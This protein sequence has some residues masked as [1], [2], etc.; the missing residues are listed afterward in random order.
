MDLVLDRDQPLHFIGVGGIG[1]SALAGILVERGFSV[2]GSDPKSNP[3]LRRLADRGVKVFSEQTEATILRLL[4]AGA[5][6]PWVVLSSAVRQTN[7]EV[8][9]A[10]RQG[11]R[12]CHRSDVLAALINGQPSIAVAGSHG[13]TTTSTLIATLLE[14]T[15]QDPTAVIGGIVPAFDSNGR[16]G[17]GRLLVAE[18]DESDGS[19]VK[20]R[21]SLAV[22]TNI[23]LDHTDH[24]PDLPSL[25]AT[26]RRFTEGS[27]ALL[28]NADC[29][30]LRE[31]FQADAWWSI[32]EGAGVEFAALALSERGDGTA[33]EFYE[34][35]V[36]VGTLDVPLPGRH[37]LSN[38]TGALAACRMEGIPFDDLRRAIGHL[39]APGRRFDCRGL[40]HER[41]VVDDYAH[42]PSEVAATLAMA[43]LMVESGSSPLP[44]QPRRLLA[45]FQ[46]HRYSR[47]AQFLSEF[48][49]ALSLADRVIVA[50]LYSAGEAPIEGVSSEALAAAVLA[51]SPSLPVQ[52][53]A[54]LDQLA[55]QV[56]AFSEPGDL[57]LAMG[58]GDVNSLWER[59]GSHDDPG[60]PAALVA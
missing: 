33:A 10:L 13:K 3:V 36:R 34:R 22:L 16:Q 46:P 50:P 6:P 38:I 26:L 17:A 19:L 24:Y 59:L 54:S 9:E 28:A 30:V 42:H 45:V 7:P 53:A 56:A 25:I 8:A 52:A 31:H 44:S 20:F 2:S 21:P 55:D 60:R 12:L 27:G 47:T 58:A 1:M 57:V 15:G 32:Q 37:N 41:I 43:R 48:A 40:W 11:L 49:E 23:E 18:A 5:P 35:G 51:I 29:P 14:A 4:A 39:R